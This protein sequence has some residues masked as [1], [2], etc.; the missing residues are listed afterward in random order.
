MSDCGAGVVTR[1]RCAVSVAQ[2]M[3]ACCMHAWFTA[4][5]DNDRAA[6][7]CRST[8]GEKESAE[9]RRRGCYVYV[10]CLGK[11]GSLGVGLEGRRGCIYIRVPLFSGW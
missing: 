4:E 5:C 7:F 3:H 8:R 6:W 11:V 1:L 10:F 2:Y 9:E